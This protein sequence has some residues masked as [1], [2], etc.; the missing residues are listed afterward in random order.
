[1]G[2]SGY[3]RLRRLRCG[4]EEDRD[5]IGKLDTREKGAEKT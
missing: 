2:E 1:V 4:F 3:R 5:V